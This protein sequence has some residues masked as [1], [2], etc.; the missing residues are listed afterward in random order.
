M[1]CKSY[2]VGKPFVSFPFLI[3]YYLELMAEIMVK[4]TPPFQRHFVSD[5]LA[6]VIK[7]MSLVFRLLLQMDSH[8]RTLLGQKSSKNVSNSRSSVMK[9]RLRPLW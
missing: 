5:E 6:L 7:V 2:N 3:F 8:T 1:Y 4:F 9:S